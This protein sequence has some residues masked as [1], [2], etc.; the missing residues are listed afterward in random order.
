[1]ITTDTNADRIRFLRENLPP[2]GLFQGKTWRTSP[3]AFP[4]SPELVAQ[5]EEL[6]PRLLKF[7]KSLDQIYLTSTREKTPA[8][9]AD[10]IHKGKPPELVEYALG[11]EFRESVP[12]VIRPDVILTEDGIAITELD[13]VPGGIGLTGWLN[14]VYHELAEDVV[15][16]PTGMLDGFAGI[17]QGD[18]VDI[19]ISEESADYRPEMVWLSE[20]LRRRGAGNFRVR[21]AETAADAW[22]PEVYRFFELFDLPNLPAVSALMQANRHG[23]VRVT[24]PFK[25]VFEEKLWLALLWSKPLEPYWELILGR[26]YLADLQEVVPYSWVIDPAPVPHHAVIPRLQIQDWRTL[27]EFS[28]RERELVLKISGFSES[29]WGARGV[30]IGQDVRQE[31]WRDAVEH[32]IT[33]FERG[34]YVLQEFHKG[35]LV[36]HPV[37]NDDTE[38]VEMMQGRVRLCPYYFVPDPTGKETRLAGVLCTMVPADKKIIHGMTDAVIMPCGMDSG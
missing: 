34:P 37:W 10:Y 11:K 31:T 15:G 8:F 3:E 1:M 33:H 2:E 19:L 17:F 7:Y 12:Q 36:E 30:T 24:P 6:G 35:R 9:V 21:E 28:Q 23:R 22:A 20:Q 5:L 4:L 29:A 13:S 38:S 27:G 16:G 18:E 14:Q 32:A 26:R 25:P